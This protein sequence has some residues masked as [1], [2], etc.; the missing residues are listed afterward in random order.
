MAM[1]D[2][3]RTAGFVEVCVHQDLAGRERAVVARVPT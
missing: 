2:R 3:A 1:A